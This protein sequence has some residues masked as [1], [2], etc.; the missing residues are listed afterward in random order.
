[1][2]GEWISAHCVAYTNCW[3]S[4]D[5]PEREGSRVPRKGPLLLP[6]SSLPWEIGYNILKQQQWEKAVVPLGFS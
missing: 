5:S 1:M 3:V 4:H 2:Q 6:H